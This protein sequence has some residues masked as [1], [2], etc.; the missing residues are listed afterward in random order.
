MAEAY[1][2]SGNVKTLVGNWSEEAVLKEA[3]GTART[4]GKAGRLASSETQEPTAQR[5]IEHTEQLVRI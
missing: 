2:A 4:R 3:T 1:N 5:V